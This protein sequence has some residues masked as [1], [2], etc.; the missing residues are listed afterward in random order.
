MSYN[1]IKIMTNSSGQ[2]TH[3]LLTDGLSQIWEIKSKKEAERI[4]N[5]LTENSDSGW[6]YTVRGTCKNKQ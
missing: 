6:K 5:M 3:V 1:I 2:K 4:A